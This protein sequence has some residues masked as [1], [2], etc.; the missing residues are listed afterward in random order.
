MRCATSGRC[1]VTMVR[2]SAIEEERVQGMTKH[3]STCVRG[4][5]SYHSFDKMRGMRSDYMNE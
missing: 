1:G 3:A 5:T 2:V 4:I